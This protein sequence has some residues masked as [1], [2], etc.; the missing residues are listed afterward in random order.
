MVFDLT[1]PFCTPILRGIESTL[2]RSNYVPILADA[3][4]DPAR[5]DPPL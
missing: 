5:F 4:N 2:Y 3:H 1:D